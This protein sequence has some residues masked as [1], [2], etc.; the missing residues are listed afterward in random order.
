MSRRSLQNIRVKRGA[1]A[2]SDH[3]LVI[4]MLKLRLKRNPAQKNPRARYSMDRLKDRGTAD[5]FLL[6]L[7]NRFQAL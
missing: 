7:T 5:R 2:W 4:A 3:H 6:N 1:D